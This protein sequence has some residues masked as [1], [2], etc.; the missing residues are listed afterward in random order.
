[1]RHAALTVAIGHIKAIL[2][3]RPHFLIGQSITAADADG[4][5]RK[6]EEEE[7]AAAVT[8]IDFDR[9]VKYARIMRRRDRG[10]LRRRTVATTTVC[11]RS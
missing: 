9:A 3:M 5:G 6:A 11:R 2:A 10:D 8:S 4:G 1:M 7:E